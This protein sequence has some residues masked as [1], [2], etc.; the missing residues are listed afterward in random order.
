MMIPDN[1]AAPRSKIRKGLCRQRCAVIAMT[2]NAKNSRR[3]PVHVAAG[4][5]ER[6]ANPRNV[7][8]CATRQ[9]FSENGDKS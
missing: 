7:S 8:A 4:S 9:A 3:I 5:S 2:D 6:L 1:D